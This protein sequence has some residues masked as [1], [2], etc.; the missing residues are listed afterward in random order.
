MVGEASQH[1]LGGDVNLYPEAR[2]LAQHHLSKHPLFLKIHSE[3]QLLVTDLRSGRV[4]T[5]EEGEKRG[6]E[7]VR[8]LCD[9]QEEV[10]ERG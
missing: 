8:G 4:P 6:R 1:T 3:C 9:I 7:S 2:S 10:V 5:C